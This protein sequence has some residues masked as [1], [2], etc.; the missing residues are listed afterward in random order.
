M[1]SILTD[2]LT[3]RQLDER[4]HTFIKFVNNHM[5]IIRQ[6]LEISTPINTY[7]ARHSHATVLKRKGASTEMISENL[8]H[9]SLLMTKQYL[10]DFT[11][12][13][14]KEIANLLTDF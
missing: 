7:A 8:G 3:A 4:V 14:K 10:D 1:F 5:D 6:K 13:A 12:D 11:D 2:G 9:S